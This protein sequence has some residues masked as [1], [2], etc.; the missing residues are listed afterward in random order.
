MI[1]FFFIPVLVMLSCG[2]TKSN[3]SAGKSDSATVNTQQPDA[4][5]YAKDS[6]IITE[7]T[8][9]PVPACI[10]NKIDSFKLK[11]AHEKPQ[12]VIEYSYKGKKVYYVVMPCCDFFNEVYDDKC[13]F[14]GAPDGGFTGK[15]DG[16][17]PDFFAEAKNEKLVWG[18][19]K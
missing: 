16:K 6:A 5:L 19:P 17:L 15:G 2:S 9:G 3:Q 7:I 8:N 12:R 10:K 18:T 1:K 11:E 13:N 14:L 4:V